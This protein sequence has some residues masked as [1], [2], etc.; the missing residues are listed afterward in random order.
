MRLLEMR[1]RWDAAGAEH[2]LA[3]ARR[4][5]SPKYAALALAHLG[6]PQ[7]AARVATTTNSDL[8]VAQ[9][10]TPEQRIAARD[11]IAAALPA[12][13]RDTFVASGRLV[14]PPGPTR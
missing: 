13:L 10:G 7:E 8:L 3:E 6:R 4:F 1:A 14:V 5:S 9:L 12:T 2:L 11:R